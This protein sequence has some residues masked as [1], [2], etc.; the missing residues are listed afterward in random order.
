MTI[1]NNGTT[2]DRVNC[3]SC[4]VSA[5]CQIH[6][7]TMSDGVMKM[8]PVEGGLEI[9]PG[10]TVVLKPSDSHLMLTDLK[11]SLKTGDRSNLS[12]RR[13]R[14]AAHAPELRADGL[15]R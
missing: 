1:T 14:N 2:P 10:Q 11:H 4:D 8:H 7:M 15:V 3:V 6:T 9:K 12:V 13:S 5:K